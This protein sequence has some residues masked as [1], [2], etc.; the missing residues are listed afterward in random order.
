MRRTAMAEND[1]I[2][3][4]TWPG[5]RAPSMPYSLQQR[6][7]LVLDPAAGSRGMLRLDRQAQLAT[8]ADRQLDQVSQRH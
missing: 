1:I 3:A 7:D 8:G 6:R 4:H 2:R 5:R